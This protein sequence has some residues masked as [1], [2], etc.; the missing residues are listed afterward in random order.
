MIK[1]SLTPIV[2]KL[3]RI[4]GFF[5]TGNYL[6]EYIFQIDGIG[7]LI[8]N[9]FF[10]RDYPVIFAFTLIMSILIMLGNIINDIILVNI[11]KKIEFEL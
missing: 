11:N 8:F 4:I 6:I 7:L 10:D 9:S 2:S 5:F 1:N 3:G